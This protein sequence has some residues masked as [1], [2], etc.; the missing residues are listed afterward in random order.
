MAG[1]VWN[2]AKGNQQTIIVKLTGSIDEDSRLERLAA[3]L[4]KTAAPLR[5]DL[6]GVKR[7]NSCG[8]REWVNFMRSIPKTTDVVLENCA[9]IVVAQINMISNFA[10]HAKVA[11]VKAPFVCEACG[12]EEEATINVVPGSRPQFQSRACPKCGK[13][14]L[15]FDD[16]E[17]SYFAF[18]S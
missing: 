18:M 14:R 13:P 12:Y 1:L 15:I 11:S 6:S 3:D 10:G 5:F 7:I 17:E 4:K 16:L 9:P 8:V 2:F